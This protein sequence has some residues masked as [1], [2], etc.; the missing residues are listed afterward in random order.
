MTRITEKT[1]EQVLNTNT[2]DPSA[3]SQMLPTDK[4][5]TYFPRS[6]ERTDINVT[7][8]CHT[9]MGSGHSGTFKFPNKEDLDTTGEEVMTFERAK[10][11]TAHFN[12]LE[13]VDD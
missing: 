6:S 1:E 5:E 13:K 7:G 2:R 12:K 10:T 9:R 3:I 11:Q 4:S 8:D